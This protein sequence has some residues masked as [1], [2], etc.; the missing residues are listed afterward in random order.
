MRWPVKADAFDPYAMTGLAGTTTL[1][2]V[3]AEARTRLTA[4]LAVV[5]Q[6]I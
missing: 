6:E 2:D 5:E 3:P 4:G 1:D